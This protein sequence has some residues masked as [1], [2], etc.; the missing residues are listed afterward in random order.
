MTIKTIARPYAQAIFEISKETGDSDIWISDLERLSF[1]FSMEEV[2]EFLQS[3]KISLE[4]KDS[5]N[6]KIQESLNTEIFM[7]QP[8]LLENHYSE[9]FISNMA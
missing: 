2:Q 8:N 4:Q 5:L 3:P 7:Q 9:L 6:V 1:V